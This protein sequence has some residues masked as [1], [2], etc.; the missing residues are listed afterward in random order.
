[1]A[2]IRVKSNWM[3]VRM[4]ILVAV[5]VM[6]ATFVAGVEPPADDLGAM[7]TAFAATMAD[8]DLEAFSSFLDGHFCPKGPPRRGIPRGLE[9]APSTGVRESQP[10]GGVEAKG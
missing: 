9:S 3:P 2:R 8:R 5:W 4:T 6:G 7:E 10:C 1:M